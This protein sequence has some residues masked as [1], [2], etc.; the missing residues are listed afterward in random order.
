M[1]KILNILCFLGILGLFTIGFQSTSASSDIQ[2]QQRI[3]D[4]I[5]RLTLKC[6]SIEG[7]YPKNLE[8]LKRNYGLLLNEEIYRITYHYEGANL[9]PHIDVYKKE[10]A[11]EKTS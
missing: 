10:H 8:Y 3:A 2:E 7:Q 11:Y 9:A 4:T 1:K 5:E 6:Y